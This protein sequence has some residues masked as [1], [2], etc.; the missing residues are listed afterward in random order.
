MPLPFKI[1][2]KNPDYIQVFEWRADRLRRIRD[3]LNDLPYLYTYYKSHPIDFIE[4]WGM[5]FDPRNINTPIPAAMPFIL[6]PKQREWLEWVLQQWADKDPGI[7]EKSR[8][9][10]ISWLAVGL[11]SSICL[12]NDHVSIGFGSR[13]EEYVDK[14]GAPKSL[15]YKARQFIQMLPR[16]F[17]NGWDLRRDSAHMRISFRS[18]NSVISGEAGDNIGRGDRTS[19]YFVDE[20]AHLER[21]QLIEASLSATTDCRIDMSSV[22]GTDNPFAEKRFKWPAKRIF[23]FDWR[24]D[25]RKDDEWYQKKVGE[26]D[27]ITVAQEIDRD[28]SA[29]VEGIVIPG[30]WVR[31]AIDAH[32]KL[33]IKPAGVRSGALDVADEGADLNAFIGAHGIVI[34]RIEEWSGKG[35]DIYATVER[36]FDLCD[37]EGYHEFSFD[38][39]GLGSGVRG[40]A[41]KINEARKAKGQRE[42]E[43]T[44]YRGSEAVLDPESAFDPVDKDSRT[45]QDMFANFKAQAW[46]HARMLFRNTYRAVNGMDYDPNKLIAISSE[47][48]KHLKLVTELSQATYMKNS[49]GQ[50]L[51]N[52]KPDGAKSPNIADAVIIKY[53]PQRRTPSR[54]F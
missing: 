54:F 39:D 21:P 51:I 1:D 30:E 35:S 19:L 38:S 12:F 48:S 45:N 28:Y 9:V 46:W 22:A 37:E 50:F 10:G 3:N 41:R 53:A 11:A 2:F 23:I 18:T 32:I 26:L 7:T 49:A 47:C 40:D 52:K 31:A 16:E 15:F 5:T 6:F 43:V 13:K 24:D 44:A 25:P 36:A 14:H 29:S 27:P 17:R 33:G 42:I 4:D 8:D 34:E 20:S